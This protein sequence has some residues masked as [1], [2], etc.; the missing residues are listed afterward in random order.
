MLKK[1][2]IILIIMVVGVSNLSA[3]SAEEN[4]IVESIDTVKKMLTLPE[5]AIPPLL[6]QKAEAVAVIPSIYKVGLIFGG[7]FGKGIIVAKNE[8]GNF[9]NPVFIELIGG[10][11]G[12]QAGVAV[13]DLVLVFK[14]KQS[15]DGLVSSKLT[16]GTDASI[17]VGPVGREAGVGGDLFLDTEVYVYAT[18][19]GLYGGLSFAGNSII[20]DREANRAFYGTDASPTDIFN[21]YQIKTPPIVKELDKVFN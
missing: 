19:K 6:F 1:I 5:R 10:S 17:A 12:L 8:K 16:L 14:T 11:I 3:R 2:F 9:T 18:T 7:R 20:V 21:G 15:I 4:K 13:S